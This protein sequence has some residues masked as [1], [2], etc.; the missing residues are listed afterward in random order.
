MAEPEMVDHP[1]HYNAS[2]SGVECIVI[3]RHMTFN[4]GSAVKY[5][6]RHGLKGG[7]E[8]AV[9]DMKKAIWYIWDEI[10][11]VAPGARR[12]KEE[13]DKLREQV[14]YLQRAGQNAVKRLR[15]D[16]GAAFDPSFSANDCIEW[17]GSECRELQRRL[18][19]ETGPRLS[20]QLADDLLA[21]D[22]AEC[23]AAYRWTSDE[24]ERLLALVKRAASPPPAQ[25]EEGPVEG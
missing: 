10:E 24:G 25:V 7:E 8:R 21:G 9:E 11:R 13:I 16:G 4:I 19:K 22:L 6:W 12:P 20:R 17:L 15:E 18:K 1:K 23:I 3:V 2:P 14:A 5:L